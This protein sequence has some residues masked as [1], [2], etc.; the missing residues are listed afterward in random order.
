[1]ENLPREGRPGTGAYPNPTPTEGP[2]TENWKAPE[3]LLSNH[4]APQALDIRGEVETGGA[5]EPEG[6]G[7]PLRH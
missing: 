2:T 7:T 1:M 6:V 3:I 4:H 5:I